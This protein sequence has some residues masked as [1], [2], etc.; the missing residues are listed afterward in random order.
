MS[1]KI[2]S[3]LPKLPQIDAATQDLF[4]AIDAKD[5]NR[6]MVALNEG[7]NVNTV[8][9]YFISQPPNDLGGGDTPLQALCTV[10]P[11]RTIDLSILS[12]LLE[13]GADPSLKGERG[14]SALDIISQRHPGNAKGAID[15]L[16]QYGAR[17]EIE[18]LRT[19]IEARSMWTEDTQ[20][21]A[22]GEAAVLD[23]LWE[24]IPQSDRKTL[25]PT[26]IMKAVPNS[27][28]ALSYAQIKMVQWLATHCEQ[29]APRLQDKID[30]RRAVARRQANE[31]ACHKFH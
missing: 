12:S 17:P 7:A 26:W 21:L 1:N 6:V 8:R 3:H 4:A 10:Y 9:P 13:H 29:P 15:L 18:H 2:L 22:F 23:A 5:H 20:T 24:H 31:G 25:D 19:V 28:E 30:E 16:A 27:S 14:E 11:Q